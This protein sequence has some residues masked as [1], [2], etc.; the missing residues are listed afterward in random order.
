MYFSIFGAI[1]NSPSNMK[2]F[3]LSILGTVVIYLYFIIVFNLTNNF[4][5]MKKDASQ[6]Q[7]MVDGLKYQSKH[8]KDYPS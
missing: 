4:D 6:M 3:K 8:L 7:Q 1:L 5:N 2:Y